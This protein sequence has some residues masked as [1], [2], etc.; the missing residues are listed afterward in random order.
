MGKPCGVILSNLLSHQNKAYSIFKMMVLN[1]I[2]LKCVTGWQFKIGHWQGL[3]TYKP[4]IIF[5]ELWGLRF[6]E[7]NG[8]HAL[9]EVDY[10]K[11][12][13]LNNANVQASFFTK[14]WM[15]KFYRDN[16][17]NFRYFPDYEK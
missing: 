12:I 7:K 10:R 1:T 5:N 17:V 11:E 15:I 4:I 2:G 9:L 13:E 3:F 14:N 8:F 16:F 6:H